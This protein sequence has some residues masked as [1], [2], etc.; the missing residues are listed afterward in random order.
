[1]NDL[2][3]KEQLDE[4][5]AWWQENRAWVLGGIAIGL[6]VIVGVRMWS[7][8]QLTMATEAS[9]RYEAL[10]NEVADD[11]L[12]P[13]RE[14]ADELFADYSSTVYADQARLAMA[15]LYMDRGRDGDAAD[16]L[17][18]LATAGG[19]E[20]LQKVATLRLARILLYQDKPEEVLELLDASSDSAFAARINEV[21]GDAHYALGNFDEA[22]AAYN[23]VL[24]DADAHQTVD[25][26]LVRMKLNDLPQDDDGD[27]ESGDQG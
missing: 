3:E 13:A 9:S 11:N 2:T 4:L 10:V 21:R 25:A 19:S 12:D 16:V 1:V 15:R 8:A 22:A 26:A 7:G 27:A 14:I 18:P 17:R 23:A 6:A 20:P 24:A 5:R